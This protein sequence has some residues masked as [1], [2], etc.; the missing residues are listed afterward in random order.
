MTLQYILLSLY[1][2][3]ENNILY[4]FT[5]DEISTM[6]YLYLYYSNSVT[7]RLFYCVVRDIFQAMLDNG[8]SIQFS[9]LK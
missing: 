3:Y 5:I 9:P 7:R 4:V 1:T 6:T 2:Y 8:N